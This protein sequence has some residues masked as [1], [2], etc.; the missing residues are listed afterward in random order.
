MLGY[1][2][3]YGATYFRVKSNVLNGEAQLVAGFSAIGAK[4][5]TDPDAIITASFEAE[6]NRRFPGR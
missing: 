6:I 2:V 3:V 5:T 1:C 4:L